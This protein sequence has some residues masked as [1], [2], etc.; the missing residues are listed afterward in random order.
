M[1]KKSLTEEFN[2]NIQSENTIMNDYNIFKDKDSLDELRRHILERLGDI[3]GSMGE[4]NKDII[5][6]TINSETEMS[7]LTNLERSHLY[8]I[9][10]NEIFGYGP[11]TELLKDQNISEIMVNAPDEIYISINGQIMPDKSISFINDDHIMRT[12][13]KMIKSTNINLNENK[14]ITVH[15]ED[16][17]ILNAI[18]PPISSKG[19]ILTIKK[20]NKALS[21]IDDLLKI[22][23]LTPYMARFL[24]AAV[25][26][27]LNILICG[28]SSS[29]KTSLLNALGNLIS[30]NSRVITIENVNELKIKK[31]NIIHLNPI[32]NE[33]LIT[34]SLKMLPDTLIIGEI[35]KT[36]A[37]QSLNIMLDNN[38]INVL[39]TI[40]S[41]DAIETIN[42][43]ETIGYEENNISSKNMRD[44]L[45]NAIDLIINIKE[46]SD[47][48]RKITS[49]CEFNK[50]KDNEIVLKE[51]FAYKIKEVLPSGDVT[52]EYSLFKYMPRSYQKI[53]QANI[54]TV[55]DIFNN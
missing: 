17:S 32:N 39:T 51:I 36:N 54:N 2:V 45:Y 31:N 3:T 52:G 9:I 16:G 11:L 22:G 23:S 47:H 10:E 43:L 50:N 40:L 18:F 38:N 1:L 29:G 42:K 28:S 44:K 13:K 41:T 4:I 21:N 34:D 48:K 55:D 6:K 27:N 15:L 46:L 49:I 26:A 37:M 14:S 33:D 19:P 20:H 25:L 8:N 5:I 30:P 24:N 12:I 53:K 35:D 7:N